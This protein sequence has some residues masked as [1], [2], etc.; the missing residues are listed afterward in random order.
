M[1]SRQM[2]KEDLVYEYIVRH[3]QITVTD[4][5]KDSLFDKYVQKYSAELDKSPEY[6]EE[7][8]AGYIYESMLYDKTTEYLF[9]VNTFVTDQ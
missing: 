2:V 5:E 1:K 7:Q 4:A 3:E 8:M 9:S 6:V